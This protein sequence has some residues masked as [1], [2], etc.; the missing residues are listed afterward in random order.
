MTEEGR[1]REEGGKGGGR[2]KWRRER[3]SSG[4]DRDGVDVVVVGLDD[5]L[6]EA[7]LGAED[8]GSLEERKDVKAGGGRERVA[9]GIS[10][11]NEK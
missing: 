5:G 10:A 1:T 4:V 2:G 7:V 9:E 6:V 8:H 11:V 3:T